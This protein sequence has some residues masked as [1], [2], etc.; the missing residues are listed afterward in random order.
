MYRQKL[1]HS[2]SGNTKKGKSLESGCSVLLL[3]VKLRDMQMLQSNHAASISL[4]FNCERF[5]DLVLLDFPKRR[6]DCQY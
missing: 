3:Q 5:K 6:S 1:L 4:H 2:E